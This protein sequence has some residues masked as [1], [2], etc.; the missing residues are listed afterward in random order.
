MYVPNE[1]LKIFQD[2]MKQYNV[3]FEYNPMIGKERTYVSINGVHLSMTIMNDFF[4]DWYRFNCQIKEVPQ[5]T[6]FQK[7]KAKVKKIIF[8]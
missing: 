5:K 1:K 6:K 2:L 8:N 3:Y 4:A 7:F